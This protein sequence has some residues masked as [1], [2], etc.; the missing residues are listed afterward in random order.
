MRTS[1]RNFASSNAYDGAA[2]MTGRDE[3]IG[4]SGGKELANPDETQSKM[5]LLAE[6]ALQWMHV[7]H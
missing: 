1:F 5:Y 6:R 2:Q 3:F 7:K 4:M